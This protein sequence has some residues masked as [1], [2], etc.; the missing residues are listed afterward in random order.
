MSSITVR[1]LDANGKE[2]WRYQGQVLERGKDDI[3]LEARFNRPDLPF[4]GIT[5]GQNDR[6]VETF[7][8]HKWYNIFKIHDRD[9]DHLKGWY[10]NVTYPAEI[11]EEQVSYRDLA[12]DL[13][14]YADGRQLT[15]DEEEFEQLNLNMDDKQ[16]ALN[17]LQELK[18][19]FSGCTTTFMS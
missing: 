10:C 11:Q 19:L 12:L 15:L 4:H 5:I 2:I 6:F 3:T 1:K 9:D 13:L 18:E 16:A 8:A 14:V 7:F 17:A